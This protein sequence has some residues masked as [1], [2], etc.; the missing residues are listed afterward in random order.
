MRAVRSGRG[1]VR[2]TVIVAVACLLAAC[3]AILGVDYYEGEPAANSGAHGGTGGTG[4]S[5]G[6]GGS[7]GS[8]VVCVPQILASNGGWGLTVKD[9]L[10]VWTD[11]AALNGNVSY[12]TVPTNGQSGGGFGGAPTTVSNQATPSGVAV[13]GD[14]IFWT[15]SGSGGSGQGEHP[16]AIMS[17]KL[18]SQPQVVL[19]NSPSFVQLP[20]DIVANNNYLMWVNA[21]SSS[22]AA[23]R[24]YPA[25]SSC[26]VGGAGGSS[27][28]PF[29]VDNQ[30]G[31]TS[32]Y[33]SPGNGGQTHAYWL[34][35][36]TK[37]VVTAVID[38]STPVA[39]DI[40]QNQQDLYALSGNQSWLFWLTQNQTP[41]SHRVMQDDSQSTNVSNAT[42]VADN[43]ARPE[44]IAADSTYVYWTDTDTGEI[45]R[46]TGPGA[47]ETLAQG[48]NF[49]VGIAL[50]DD[51]IFWTN[52]GDGTVM[53]CE[54]PP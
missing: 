35:P 8:P 3:A 46:A 52:N 34:R 15:N 44:A 10:V 5:G 42:V 16:Q 13:V 48:Q 21:S 12:T 6:N 20:T 1:V 25:T 45:L 30:G 18:G 28:T 51:Y 43:L 29:L 33:F 24:W 23:L 54:K 49:P 53:Y 9:G 36:A 31:P 39:T 26:G 22:I 4:G 47:V 41:G 27:G 17:W 37:T 32:P 2:A 38:G 19:E 14:C 40:E 50:S 11:R 7:G